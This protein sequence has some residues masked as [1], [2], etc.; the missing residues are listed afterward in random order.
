MSRHSRY[1]QTLRVSV[2]N[3][4]RPSRLRRASTAPGSRTFLAT[5]PLPPRE[6]LVSDTRYVVQPGDRPDLIAAKLLG[7]SLQYWRLC[8][9]NSIPNPF[10]LTAQPGRSLIVPPPAADGTDTFHEPRA[11]GTTSRVQAPVHIEADLDEG[12]E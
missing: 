10:D 9:A 5:R 11:Q 1:P 4:G 7:D 3:P 8:D 6:T 2:S 12:D